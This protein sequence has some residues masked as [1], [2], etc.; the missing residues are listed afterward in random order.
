MNIKSN[1]VTEYGKFKAGQYIKIESR[2]TFYSYGRIDDIE[3]VE[4]SP[5]KLSANSTNMP[6][7]YINFTQPN[8]SKNWVVPYNWTIEILDI[9]DEMQ[10]RLL[11]S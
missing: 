1:R 9:D 5:A 6:T 8:G 4:G 7:F 2:G 3:I 10:Y 11:I